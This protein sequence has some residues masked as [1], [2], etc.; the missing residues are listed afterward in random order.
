MPV[1]HIHLVRERYSD[2]Q[3]ASL[4]QRAS[5]VYAETLD[6]PVDRVRVF[7]VRYPAT[8]VA[9]AG[10]VVADDG[11][12]APYFTALALAGRPAAQRRELLSRLTD[13]LVEELGCRRELVRGRIEQVDPQDWAIGGR[14]AS[15]VRSAEIAAR[16]AGPPV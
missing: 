1:A 8:D 2:T 5:Y 4:L 3:V 13:V 10:Q 9:T 12:D 11:E 7:A 6:S 16:Q 14:P 15:A